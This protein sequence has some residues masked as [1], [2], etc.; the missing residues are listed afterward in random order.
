MRR[1]F[2]M[3]AL[4]VYSFMGPLLS[5]QEQDTHLMFKQTEIK[6]T[7]HEFLAEMKSKGFVPVSNDSAE[8]SGQFAGYAVA[9]TTDVT[10]LTETVYQVCARL[11]PKS[12][13][14]EAE[15]D[16][17]V[18]KTNLTR[19]YG[20]PAIAKEQFHSPYRKGDGYEL[21]AAANGK[22]EYIS[23]WILPA[24][25]IT[26]QVVSGGRDFRLLIRYADAAGRELQEAEKTEIFLRDL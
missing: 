6:G 7:R 2:L 18:F 11:E 15:D 25:E 19:K 16:Y 22:V 1:I 4:F 26:I 8:M 10:P 5:A 17:A 23:C 21:K 3:T 12:S 24:G 13:W 9:V 14:K 20:E